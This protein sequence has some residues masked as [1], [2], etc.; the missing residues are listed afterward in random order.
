MC[1]EFF[2][3]DLSPAR[4]AKR[5]LQKMVSRWIWGETG[6]RAVAA[7]A[8]WPT[9]KSGLHRHHHCSSV[10]QPWS[11]SFLH[12]LAQSWALSFLPWW[13]Q[14]VMM[15]NLMIGRSV[16][17]GENLSLSREEMDGERGM[18]QSSNKNVS[19]YCDAFILKL[20]QLEWPTS[21][22]FLLPTN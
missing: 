18:Q 12:H 4:G 11:Y 15:T 8:R 9:Q 5:G 3:R 20:R 1:L 13:G 6:I 7:D 10:A 21:K 22:P 17:R 19:T 14:G 2:W 16:G